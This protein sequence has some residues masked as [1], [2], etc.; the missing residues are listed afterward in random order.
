[1]VKVITKQP[2]GN[3]TTLI[4]VVHVKLGTTGTLPEMGLCQ[5]CVVCEQDKE[6]YQLSDIIRP[7]KSR[8]SLTNNPSELRI[9]DDHYQAIKDGEIHYQTCVA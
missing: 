7:V 6:H 3:E 2:K 8:T 5:K 9:E 4:R 1:M